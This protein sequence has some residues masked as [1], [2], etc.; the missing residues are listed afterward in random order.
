MKPT[1][2]L[3]KLCKDAKVDPPVYADGLVKVGKQLFSVQTDDLDFYKNKEAEEQMALAVLQ[4][5]VILK[6]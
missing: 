1:Q 2:I 6:I 4:R 3:A 5:Y